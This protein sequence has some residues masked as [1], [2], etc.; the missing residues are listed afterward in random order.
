MY[1][2]ADPAA[3]LPAVP[4]RQARWLVAG[5]ATAAV[6]TAIR[7]P[8]DAAATAVVALTLASLAAGSGRAAAWTVL[9]V[10]AGGALAGWLGLSA[11]VGA[12]A[13]AAWSAARRA[14]H[15]TDRLDG[16]LALLAGAGCAGLALWVSSGL[17]SMV[18]MALVLGATAQALLPSAWRHDHPD[19]PTS[20]QVVRL[21]ASHRPVARRA[22][23]LLRESAPMAPD[24][25]TRRGLH[26]VTRWI[27]ALQQTDVALQ[28]ELDR[29]DPTALG[30]RL[31]RP[32]PQSD[33]AFTRD[34]ARAARSHV[35]RM[36][37][38]HDALCAE[39]GRTRALVDHALAWLDDARTSLA[40]ARLRP[41]LAAPTDV[42]GV[43]LRL[44]A[45]A[46]EADAARRTARELGAAAL[47]AG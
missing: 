37:Q 7:W 10:P 6:L 23:T 45:H 44:R 25:T 26:E 2:P 27:L 28:A 30:Q 11:V 31:A 16:V 36:A 5:L 35:Q 29:L 1:A 21:P 22:L 9:A 47:T 4:R 12:G 3:A 43:L 41:G 13:A 34:R 15:P 8:I 42:D 18:T 19:L 32:D 14:P 38:H 20:W 39:L 40:L 17:P 33:D 46:V 24:V